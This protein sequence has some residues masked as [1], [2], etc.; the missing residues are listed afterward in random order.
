MSYT[1]DARAAFS[2]ACLAEM[3]NTLPAPSVG[4]LE[5]FRAVSPLSSER[6]WRC[7]QLISSQRESALW[8]KAME[9]KAAPLRRDTRKISISAA[10]EV[11]KS[12]ETGKAIDYSLKR[13]DAL[14][15][16]LNDGRLCMSNNAA[17][18]ELRAVAVGR[19]NW[20]FAGSVDPMKEAGGQPPSTR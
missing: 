18:R 7:C 15:R 5:L 13:W 19:R 8:R 20:T 1:R 3:S 12:S 11:S 17:E 14:T 6:R 2:C 16:F 9:L 10:R 4:E